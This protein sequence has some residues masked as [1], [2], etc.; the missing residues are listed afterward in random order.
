M[1]YKIGDL[2]RF[3]DEPIEGHITAFLKNG[4]VGVTDETGFEK[5]ILKPAYPLRIRLFA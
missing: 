1:N 5:I 2:V 3:V 4:L